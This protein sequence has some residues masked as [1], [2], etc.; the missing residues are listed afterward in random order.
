MSCDSQCPTLGVLH[1]TLGVAT[2]FLNFVSLNEISALQVILCRFE[3]LINV[4]VHDVHSVI[5]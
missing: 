4:Y 2:Y 5:L 1:W 3:I